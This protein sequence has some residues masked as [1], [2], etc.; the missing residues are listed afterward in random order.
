MPI[1]EHGAQSQDGGAGIPSGE[2]DG[3][4]TASLIE[5]GAN[6]V[7]EL[8]PHDVLFGR[9]APNCFY[10]GNLYYRD[11]IRPRKAA[12]MGTGRHR[13]KQQI[14]QDIFALIQAENGRFLRRITSSDEAKSFGLSK[15]IPA[16]VMVKKEAAL[17]K[18]KQALRE[19]ESK[20]SVET[21]FLKLASVV[22]EADFESKRNVKPTS[23][24]MDPLASTAI[25]SSDAP[26]TPVASETALRPRESELAGWL[27]SAAVSTPLDAVDLQR[28]LYEQSLQRQQLLQQQYRDMLALR[29][30]TLESLPR[31]IDLTLHQA[32]YLHYN[33]LQESLLQNP[34]SGLVPS[35]AVNHHCS[36]MA[37]PNSRPNER[38]EPNGPQLTQLAASPYTSAWLGL[39]ASDVS[40]YVN[41]IATSPTSTVQNLQSGGPTK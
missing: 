6:L 28:V 13:V 24:H 21:E 29:F 35:L 32:S 37:L 40:M 34:V 7:M 3:S 26:L 20:T 36:S 10:I 27:P 39:D 18:I 15:D 30:A 25:A 8:N 17:R 11:L 31:G 1:A 4:L 23:T 16:Y 9:G 2:Q 33:R 12:F 5:N 19:D 14:A 38:L 22:A 41:S